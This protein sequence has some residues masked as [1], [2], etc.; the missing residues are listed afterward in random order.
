ML[1]KHRHTHCRFNLAIILLFP[2]S[3]T[4]FRSASSSRTFTTALSTQNMGVTDYKYKLRPYEPSTDRCALDDI[5]AKV[6]DGGDYLPKV[7]ETYAADPLCSFLTL[8]GMAE[9]DEI[10]AVA[11]YKR[12]PLQNSAWIEA[13]RTYPDHQN[14]GLASSLLRELINLSKQEDEDNESTDKTTILTCTIESNKGMQR[15]LE[16][17]GFK[18]YSTIPALSFAALKQ[19]PG[20]SVECPKS[21]QPLLTAL[22]L[23]HLVSNEARAIAESDKWTTVT[24][25]DQLLLALAECK[26][27][28]GTCGYLPGL[29]EYI[30]PSPSRVDL[31]QSMEHGLVFTLGISDKDI[32]GCDEDSQTHV[33]KAILAFTKDERISSLKSQW[34]CSIVAY[35]TISF[36]AALVY[37]HSSNVAKHMQHPNRD[38]TAHDRLKEDCIPKPFCL[39]FDEAVPLHDGT[40]AHALPRVADD[41][42][43]FSYVHD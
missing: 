31:Q 25:N 24:S 19:L 12:L 7:A 29:Y 13:V 1:F 34:V 11:N 22:N 20:W 32:S 8:A 6:Y 16:K 30:V 36:E 23:D 15:A 35:S 9:S 42:V 33:G 18:R 4:A 2:A 26:Q 3:S 17:V 10:V 28:G 5:C 37:A 41:C 38:I 27:H 21:P 43:V 14:K 40:L 39:V